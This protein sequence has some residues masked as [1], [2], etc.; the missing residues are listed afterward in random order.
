MGLQPWWETIRVDPTT[1][2]FVVTAT[3]SAVVSLG[4]LWKSEQA[5]TP[6]TYLGTVFYHSP[7]AGAI[8]VLLVETGYVNHPCSFG[9]GVLYAAGIVTINFLQEMLLRSL[10]GRKAG[11]NG[12]GSGN[13]AGDTNESK[14]S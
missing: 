4:L 3:V 9:I 5:L 1:A 10:G 2:T 11:R 7:V 14:N 8:A 12:N 6:R 13:G